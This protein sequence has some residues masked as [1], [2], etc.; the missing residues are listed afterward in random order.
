MSIR[1]LILL[2]FLNLSYMFAH[3]FVTSLRCYVAADLACLCP[4]LNF[5][6]LCHTSD[7]PRGPFGLM[8]LNHVVPEALAIDLVALPPFTCV[9]HAPYPGVACVPGSGVV[10]L[11]AT[12]DCCNMLASMISFLMHYH[13]LMMLL[14]VHSARMPAQFLTYFLQI[15]HVAYHA[16]LSKHH[17]TG[18][19]L[20]HDLSIH[21]THD[22]FAFLALWPKLCTTLYV[23][24][25]LASYCSRPCR[26]SEPP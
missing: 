15:G 20:S 13:G 26:D 25:G 10:D 8:S 19:A 23:D 21:H 22:T 6:C 9:T 18:K 5:M 17:A 12:L 4:C 11:Y 16:G 14:A 3:L 1:M 7:H 24:M 2:R